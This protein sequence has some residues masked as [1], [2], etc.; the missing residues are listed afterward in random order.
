MGWVIFWAA[1]AA[2]TGLLAIF[3]IGYLIR[4]NT[5]GLT[6]QKAKK[7]RQFKNSMRYWAIMGAVF[8][9]AGSALTMRFNGITGNEAA[10]WLVF[11]AIVGTGWGAFWGAF[12]AMTSRG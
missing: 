3:L 4:A 8:G 2:T 11:G 1:I 9:V 12:W 5:R 10:F 6:G 7:L